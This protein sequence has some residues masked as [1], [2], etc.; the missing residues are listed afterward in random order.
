MGI[1][2]KILGGLKKTA[3]AISGGISAVFTKNLD[4]EFF[5]ELEAILL[6]ADI[7][8][9]ATDEIIEDIRR[10]A[11]KQGIKTEQEL[12]QALAESIANILDEEENLEFPTQSIIM[13]VGVNGVGKTTSIGKLASYFK[14]NKKSVLIAAGDTFRAAAT[15]QLDTWAQRAGVRIVKQG[16]GAD[17]SAV[18]FDALAS[19]KAKGD[20]IT[21]IDT[22]GRLHN[23]VGLMEEL[24]KIDRV[25]ARQMPEANYYKLLVLDA[26]TGQNAIEQAKIFNDAINLDGIILTKLDGTAKGGIVLSI[27]KKLGLPV[28]MV[29]VGEKIDDLLPFN[30][31]EFANGLVGLV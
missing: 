10:V 17:S 4:E 23:K 24:K 16:E 14:A 12:K 31:K 7:G 18:V 29:G 3:T 21:I 28:I 19:S 11:K 8:I 27:K 25:V 5:E 15:E 26:T 9:E 6:Q 13:I 2:G 22:A 20:D 30:A 1:F